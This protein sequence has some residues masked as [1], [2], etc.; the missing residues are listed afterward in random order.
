MIRNATLEKGYS[1]RLDIDFVGAAK[2]DAKSNFFSVLIG[3][4]GTSKSMILG[5]LAN[6]LRSGKDSMSASNDINVIAI[7]L[8]SN[9]SRVVAISMSPFDRF[10]SKSSQSGGQDNADSN[11]QRNYFY[12]GLKGKGNSGLRNMKDRVYEAILSGLSGMYIE[13]VK[14]ALQTC[15]DMLNFDFEIRLRWRE[16]RKSPEND[17]ELDTMSTLL[18]FSDSIEGDFREISLHT[19]AEVNQ[20]VNSIIRGIR[21]LEK[22]KIIKVEGVFVRKRGSDQSFDLLEASSG[23]LSLLLYYMD[24]AAHLTDRTVILIDEPEISLHPT[25]QIT[26]IEN[27]QRISAFFF[28][29]HFIIATHSPHIVT[30]LPVDSSN[31]VALATGDDG[32]LRVREIR[33]SPAGWS[34][35]KILLDVFGVQTVRNAYFEKE[36]RTLLYAIADREYAN[37]K[38]TILNCI[39]FLEKFK[40]DLNDP[41]VPIIRDAKEVLEND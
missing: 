30:G 22:A 19:L 18:G 26:F 28:G 4:N 3:P 15:F 35:E 21:E 9:V 11:Q 38:A 24:L 34:V 1:D 37:R 36:V 39:R 13:Q 17:R 23:E 31:V 41:I 5:A 6:Y 12:L 2:P 7:G 8:T 40:L 14:S 25:W 32:S 16:R 27:I 10:Y 29:C 33:S 20:E